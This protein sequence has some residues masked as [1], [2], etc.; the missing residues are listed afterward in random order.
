M[1]ADNGIADDGTTLLN[2]PSVAQQSTIAPTDHGDGSFTWDEIL[3]HLVGS[4]RA[5]KL[6]HGT[7]G[8][9]A[10]IPS[11]IG[12][13]PALVPTAV[14]TANYSAAAG[15]LVPVDTTSGAVTVTLPSAPA[16]KTRIAVKLVIQGGTNAVTI[17]RGGSDVFNKTGGSTSL[18]LS[19]LFQAVSLQYKASG[20][21]WYVVGDDLPLGDL[22][23]RYVLGALDTDGAL[24]ANSDTRV[25]SQKAVK[26]YADA[27]IAAND[28]MVFKGVID[29]SA[30]PN[31][32]A[33]NR[34]DTYRVSVSGKIGGASGTNVEAGDLLICLTDGTAAGTQA[35]V[36]ASWTIV[37]ANIDGA[38]TGPASSTDSNLA[39]FNGTAGKTIKDSGL[40][41]DTSGTLSANSD[42]KVPSQ[43]A[44]KTYADA[45][46]AAAV[47]KT[48]FDAN[49][50]LAATTDDT[51]VALTVPAST[52]LGR[53]AS[54]GISAMS[55]AE[56]AAL[57][58]D[59]L[60][61][62]A[63]DLNPFLT[64]TDHS[65]WQ[66]QAVDTASF[67]FKARGVTGGTQN[68]YIAWDINLAPGTWR[69]DFLLDN[70]SDRG[71]YTLSLDGTALSTFSG[72]AD[73]I[74]GYAASETPNT[75]A[76]VTGI[77]IPA[78]GVRRFKLLMATK[79]AGSTSYKAAVQWIRWQ[80]TA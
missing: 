52:F 14:K 21:I 58:T 54:G 80:R 76:A 57:L 66:A 79:N 28:A 71:I 4:H 40:S 17:A 46:D 48:L 43:K 25:A 36:G 47:P 64:P 12:A 6:A 5:H 27:L 78:V 18:A 15:D 26:T 75:A 8:R 61:P 34:G 7:G 55:V 73:T 33:A 16:D 23:A 50:I 67:M 60:M 69:V 37:Q 72:S 30:N 24:T 49:T 65:G 53:K 44:V 29:C 10:L 56:A 63:I 59:L 77:V 22:D 31:Y 3:R 19:L 41:L 42:T 1:A 62:R 35:G 70:W 11:D 9:D 13:S 32:P 38:V 51:P 39:S 68:Q 20:G 74:D 2:L 45:G